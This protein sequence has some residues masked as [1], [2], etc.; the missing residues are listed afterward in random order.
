MKEITEIICNTGEWHSL[1]YKKVWIQLELVTVIS[2]ESIRNAKEL[3]LL[4]GILVT[5]CN[6]AVTCHVNLSYES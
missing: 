1:I 4:G 2:C 6:K 3:R 5:A